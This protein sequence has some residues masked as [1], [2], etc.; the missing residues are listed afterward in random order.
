[1]FENKTNITDFR[2]KQLLGKAFEFCLIAF[3]AGVFCVYGIMKVIGGQLA[4]L[5]SSEKYH[6]ALVSDLKPVNL[7]WLF[8]AASP[9]YAKSIGLAQI[10]ATVLICIPITRKIGLLLYLFLISQIVL[11]NFCFD[12]TVVTKYLS[13]LLLLNTC[14]LIYLYRSSYKI[15]FVF[16]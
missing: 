14:V 9:V 11:I 1:M 4:S 3:N 12:I 7:M 5:S 6:H 2:I 10:F 15:L 16:Q 13:L 8:H